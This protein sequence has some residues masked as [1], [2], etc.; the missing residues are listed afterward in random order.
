M[1]RCDRAWWLAAEPEPEPELQSGVSCTRDAA[2]KGTASVWEQWGSHIWTEVTARQVVA[3]DVAIRAACKAGCRWLLHIDVDEA[4]C[5]GG[6]QPSTSGQQPNPRGAAT[7]F[8]QR[9]PQ[10]PL[11]DCGAL[12]RRHVGSSGQMNL[13]SRLDS[14]VQMWHP[15]SGARQEAGLPQPLAKTQ[16]RRVS[17]ATPV[18]DLL[19]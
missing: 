9:L 10:M 13:S 7:Q 15:L 18:D 3:I 2:Q 8:F 16:T 6:L 14:S 11:P 17:A 1:H 5:C 12:H 19:S 4:F